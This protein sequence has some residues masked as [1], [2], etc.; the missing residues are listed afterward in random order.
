MKH[1]LLS[2]CAYLYASFCFA[3][4]TAQEAFQ[5]GNQAAGEDQRNLASGSI[6]QDR[7]GEVISGFDPSLRPSGSQEYSGNILTTLKSFGSEKSNNCV[8]GQNDGSRGAE[9]HCEAVNAILDNGNA[10]HSIIVTPDDPLIQAARGVINNPEA[11]AGQME[12]AYTACESKTQLVSA[13]FEM[14]TCDEWTES[15]GARCMVGRVVT[16]DPNYK[17]QCLETLATIDRSM[18][19]YGNSVLVDKHY[20]YQCAKTRPLEVHHCRRRAIPEVITE[21]EQSTIATQPNGTVLFSGYTAAYWLGY[22]AVYSLGT[23][24]H[25]RVAVGTKPRQ[26]YVAD[27]TIPSGSF[28]GTICANNSNSSCR[29]SPGS[30]SCGE[31][32]CTVS[33]A[34]YDT[35]VG[36]YVWYSAS[37]AR[38]QGQLVPVQKLN[39]RW[40][41]ECQ[42]FANR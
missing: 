26:S 38:P 19:T 9:Q 35:W 21:Y 39:V 32:T 24:T 33:W 1:L 8:L 16:N 13:P 2:C 42:F 4:M 14:E 27:V 36:G 40:D 31:A 10:N 29:P 6:R 20:N 28:S 22:V 41:D 7:A 18:C 30:V 25:V 34:E 3:Q 23:T 12:S 15:V 37:F 5:Y 17:Y 11:I